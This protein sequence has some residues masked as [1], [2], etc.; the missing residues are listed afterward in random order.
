VLK[1][2]PAC[3]PHRGTT[4]VYLFYD[5]SFNTQIK[6]IDCVVTQL[7]TDNKWWI[8]PDDSHD[9]KRFEDIDPFDTAE[10]AYAALRL[11]A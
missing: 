1:L 9:E 2:K 10:A 6:G 4:V 7:A 11:L 5:N 8:V 3:E